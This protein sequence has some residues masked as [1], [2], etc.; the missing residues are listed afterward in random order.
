MNPL[1]RFFALALFVV[2]AALVALL[3]AP[4][5]NEFHTAS[6]GTRA[7]IPEAAPAP[8]AG[9]YPARLV[10]LSQRLALAFAIVG[11]ALALALVVS[12]ARRSPRN[13]DSQS[14]FAAVRTEVGALAKLAE[15][16][17]A[18][19]RE[20]DR[21]RDVRRRAE[22][23]VQIKQQLL[24]HSVEEKIRLGQDLHDGIIQSLY[25]VGLNVESVRSL[26]KSDPGEAD[27]RLEQ[28]R[29]GLNKTIRDVRTYITGLTPANLRRAS[30]GYAVRS[31]I[32]ELTVGHEGNFTIEIDDDAAVLLTPEQ[33][34]EALQIAR[35]AVSNALRHGHASEVVLR[36]H[37][38]DREI[39]LLVQD[40]GVGFAAGKN[41]I[42][43]HGL[44]NMQARAARLGATLRVTSEPGSGARVIATL[45]IVQPAA[46]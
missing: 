9:S 41:R 4:A 22:E 30:F 18:Q 44:G 33:S 17:V 34:L 2:L 6:A 35:E 1:P 28:T 20:L 15:T 23:D 45:P 40:N 29:A 27:R 19:S 21:E 26:V 5:W 24:A 12:L 13:A 10:A 36:M 46:V 38:S 39:C 25:A 42:G 11:A 14:P 43:G 31:L 8:N 16:S 3:A 7:I 37:K 32:N